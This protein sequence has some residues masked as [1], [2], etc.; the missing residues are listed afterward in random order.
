MTRTIGL[1]GGESCGKSTLAA[2][3]VNSSDESNEIVATKEVLRGFTTVNGR[4]PERHEQAEILCRQIEEEKESIL[5]V[6]GK[7]GIV[8]ADPSVLMTAVYSLMYFDDDSLIDLAIKH[9]RSYDLNVL[10]GME[11]P[12][13]SDVGQ[14]DGPDFRLRAHHIIEDLSGRYELN[15]VRV[16]GSP[17]E[18]AKQ[19]L[20]A[21]PTA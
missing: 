3:L 15:L 11:I 12:W 6:G 21:L 2:E 13:T 9:S 1:L 17:Q 8:V 10:C 4:S 14:R 20:K 19:V 16:Q 18:R 5:Q 7:N